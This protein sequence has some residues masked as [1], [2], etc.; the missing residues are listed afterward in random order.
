MTKLQG[1]NQ[2]IRDSKILQEEEK[3]LKEVEAAKLLGE[4]RETV[5]AQAFGGTDVTEGSAEDTAKAE[6][7]SREKSASRVG[8]VRRVPRP[9]SA[10]G[11]NLSTSI[12]AAASSITSQQRTQ[13]RPE[14]ANG[15]WLHVR[16]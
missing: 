9:T 7:R 16:N 10:T 5:I 1:Q 2:Y 12:S 15:T 4:T 8:T 3:Y 13:Q 14:S 11:I 6:T